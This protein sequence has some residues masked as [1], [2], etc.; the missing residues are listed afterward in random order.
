[1]ANDYH[2]S[3]SVTNPDGST[4]TL[5]GTLALSTSEEPITP[6]DPIEP[7][8]LG[9]IGLTYIRKIG[10]PSMWM[11]YAYGDCTGRVVDG[12]VRLLFTG[13]NVGQG[14]PV[15]EVEITADPVAR[16]VRSWE[17]PYHGKRGTWMMVSSMLASSRSLRDLAKQLHLP[18]LEQTAVLYLLLYQKARKEGKS[19]NEW[20]YVDFDAGSYPVVT[21]GHYFH[22]EL[23]LLFVTYGDTYN[24]AG[25]PDWNC[26]AL[27][28]ND[29]GTCEAYGPWRFSGIDSDGTVRYGMKIAACLREHP[30]SKLVITST[31]LSSGNVGCPWGA[32]LFGGAIWPSQ[33]TPVG[34]GTDLVLP[35][36]YLWHY[37]MG[38]DIDRVSGIAQGPIRSQRRPI[39]AYIYDGTA[40]GQNNFI[41]PAHYHGIGSWTDSD[42]LV[43]FLPLDDRVTFFG[44]VAGS[45]ILDPQDCLSCHTWYATG[46]NNWRCPH[47]C[48]AVPASITGPVA[49][50]RYPCAFN[51]DWSDLNKVKEGNAVDYEQEPTAWSNLEKD[52]GIV[53]APIDSV[54]NAKLNAAGFFNPETRRLY[55]IAQGADRGEVTWGVINAYIHE[56][57]VD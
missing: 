19:G 53:T 11:A 1:M 44:G 10:L 2:V 22:A 50:A 30:V 26:V 57:Q 55:T 8:A 12:K 5:A 14:S 33:A 25:R 6:P 31:G 46:L 47:G 32:N 20:V 3:L 38:G 36:K 39:D 23:N 43:G 51:Y 15:Y 29:D 17:R 37:Y 48:D 13:D 56:W 9:A 24:V 40:E 7:P 45:P 52:F 54:G 16:L 49:T 28:L 27:H 41:N 42:S 4:K 35:D 21:S 18:Q 34:P